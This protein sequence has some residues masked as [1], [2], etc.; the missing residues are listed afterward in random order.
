MSSKKRGLGNG[1]GLDAL[2]GAVRQAKEEVAVAETGQYSA[3]G[4]EFIKFTA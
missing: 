3:D 4:Y 1:R 2:L